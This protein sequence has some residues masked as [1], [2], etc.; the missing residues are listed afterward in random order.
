[1]G[2]PKQH[3]ELF[4]KTF[5]ERVLD[6]LEIAVSGTSSVL[7]PRLFVGREGDDRARALV[8]ARSGIWIINPRPEDGPLGSIHLALSHLP[9]SAGFV[10]WPV[11]HPMVSSDT[12]QTILSAA[13]EAT[14]S[15]IVPSDGIHRGHPSRFPAWARDEL[16][17]APLGQGAR[18]ILQNHP[19][20]IV[21]VLVK[22]PWI[23]R[24]INTREALEEA[25]LWLK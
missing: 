19:D 12:V 14:E 1:M 2:N 13:G 18:W 11:D 7:N 17:A 4:G 23:T 10:L 8:E 16:L 15:I 6:T 9:A 25:T 22:D 3:V 24:N 20:R 5:L 21:H